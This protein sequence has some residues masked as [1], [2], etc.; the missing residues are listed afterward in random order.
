MHIH[1]VINDTTLNVICNS[2]NLEATTDVDNFDIGKVSA[3]QMNR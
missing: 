2:I 3:T 1:E